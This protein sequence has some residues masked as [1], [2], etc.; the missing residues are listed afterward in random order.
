MESGGQSR[1][2]CRNQRQ[3]MDWA[4]VLASQG[5]GAVIDNADGWSLIVATRD[6]PAALE[7]IRLYHL[8]NRHWRWRQPVGQGFLFDWS[9]ILWAG[10]L[11]AVFWLSRTIRPDWERAGCM[12]NSA[13]LAGEWWRPFTATLLHASIA[14]L[15]AN[16]SLGTILVGLAMGRYG[17]GLGLLAVCLAGVGG[18][19]AALAIYPESHLGVGASGMVMGGLGMLT[20]QSLGSLREHPSRRK[21]AL[22][23][24]IAGMLLFVLFGLSPEADIVAHLGGFASGLMLGWVLIRF[25]AVCHNPKMNLA[26]GLVLAALVIATGWR[27]FR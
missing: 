17:G 1:I 18:N 26:A 10:S 15:A 22:Q 24:L 25:P 9:V 21:F 12:D 14:H 23:S 19:L 3:T 8:E 27:A 4:L 13:V 20:V 6:Y 2:P 5:I 7:N 16:L 11:V